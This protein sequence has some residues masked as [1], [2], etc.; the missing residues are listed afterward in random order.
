MPLE[1]DID[2][3]AFLASF[4]TQLLDSVCTCVAAKKWR[5]ERSE[6]ISQLPEVV[7]LS[8]GPALVTDQSPREEAGPFS[9]GTGSLGSRPITQEVTGFL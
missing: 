9:A 7:P 6:Q 8:Q 5:M 3:P 2:V 4:S 1:V